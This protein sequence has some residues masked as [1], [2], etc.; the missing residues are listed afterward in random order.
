MVSELLAK[1]EALLIQRR[2]RVR[3]GVV[4]P[5]STCELPS[6]CSPATMWYRRR[7]SELSSDTYIGGQ[8]FS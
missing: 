5:A 6:T 1:R 7:D 2:G 4:G 8:E 3:K